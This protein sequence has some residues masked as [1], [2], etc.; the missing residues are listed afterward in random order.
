LEDFVF[1]L[2]Y[3]SSATQPFSVDDLST[4][5]AVSR[6]NNAE[7]GITGMLLYKDGN[8]M[9]VLEGDERT[10]RALYEKIGVDPRHS[11]EITLLQGF[12]DERQFPDWSMG[13][14]DLNSPE[15]RATQSYSEFLNTPLTGQ[16]FS[17][18]P[19]RS[20]KLLLTFKRTM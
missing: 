17:G 15:I 4:L 13:F 19:S 6:K 20:Q 3:I 1:F 16:E 9:Q 11:G 2:V 7:L 10:V 14:R 12:V 18:D 5:L 8:F